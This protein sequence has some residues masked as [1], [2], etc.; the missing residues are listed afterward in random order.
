[1][2]AG[3][4]ALGLLAREL[5]YCHLYSLLRNDS[6]SVPAGRGGAERRL[7][8][9]LLGTRSC[10]VVRSAKHERR[11]LEW[12]LKGMRMLSK[13]VAPSSS[14]PVVPHQS[15]RDLLRLCSGIMSKFL[16]CVLFAVLYS[17]LVNS[18]PVRDL[19]SS[20]SSSTSS[21]AT[22]TDS[23]PPI[24]SPTVPYASDDPNY[25]LWNETTTIDPEPERGTLGASILGPQNVPIE[26]QN[27]DILAP[28]TTDSGSV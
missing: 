28:P 11:D 12:P 25:W 5:V 9:V 18:I 14:S 2:L 3:L 7:H 17:S 21:A 10:Q 24:P 27:P 15:H 19:S 16:S 8:L 22:S 6:S 23:S 1:M 20:S 26:K 4:L 13:S